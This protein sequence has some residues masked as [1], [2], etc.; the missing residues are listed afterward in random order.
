MERAGSTTQQ[1]IE[2][3]YRIRQERSNCAYRGQTRL[4]PHERPGGYA[5]GSPGF[6]TQRQADYCS[7]GGP[8][9]CGG[10][11]ADTR[12]RRSTGCWRCYIARF[13]EE[14][15]NVAAVHARDLPSAQDLLERARKIFNIRQLI[16]DRIIHC[17]CCQSGAGNGWLDRLSGRRVELWEREKIL[18]MPR[19]QKSLPWKTGY[20]AH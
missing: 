14:E 16:I 4:C 6:R 20:P 13:A 10:A 2:R 17:S 8:P 15:V 11:G 1:I 18:Q 5:P 9:G 12:A 19:W 3:M 7:A